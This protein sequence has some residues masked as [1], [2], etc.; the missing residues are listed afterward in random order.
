M[1]LLVQPSKIVS[2]L[3]WKKA[4]GSVLTLDI[5]KDRIGM[6]L[7]SHPA[8]QDGVQTLESVTLLSKGEVSEEVRVSLSKVVSEHNVCGVIVSWP[9]QQDTGKMGAACGRVLHTLEDFLKDSKYVPKGPLPLC[10]WDGVHPHQEHEDQWG[11]CTAYCR[12]SN[13]SIHRASEEQYNQDENIVAVQVWNDF[14]RT[15]WPEIH[16]QSAKYSTTSSRVEER[17]DQTLL[18]EDTGVIPLCM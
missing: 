11:R 9:L 5:H 8:V 18:K 17:D 7:A 2:A 6:A 15:H 10:L 12:T 1:K 3:D 16:E 13:K 4:R 14:V